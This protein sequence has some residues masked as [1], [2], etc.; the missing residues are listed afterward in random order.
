MRKQIEK[1]SGRHLASY[2]AAAGLG[3][4][5]IGSHAQAAIVFTDVD[6]DQNVTSAFEVDFDGDGFI[7]AAVIKAGLTVQV[8]SFGFDELTMGVWLTDNFTLSTLEDPSV[9]GTAYY[10]ASFAS[11]ALIDGAALQ[12]SKFG[13]SIG[14]RETAGGFVYNFIG[15]GQF[16]GIQF[17][18]GNDPGET[19]GSGIDRPAGS[20]THFGWIEVDAGPSVSAV[21]KSFAYETVPNAGILAGNTGV[22]DGDL[23]GDGF[24]GIEDLNLVLGDWN[25]SPPTD[26][27]AD[28]TGDNF[29]G[30]ED[31]NLVLGNW[32]AGTPPA[33]SALVPEPATLVLLAAGL[34]AAA[35][36]R[37]REMV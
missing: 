29:V 10:A 34:G 21:V 3:A 23:N 32:N 24:V 25:A 18:I 22:L 16:V 36:R 27:A 7:D 4:F 26:P 5:A 9:P 12:V 14:L 8:R 30:I 20:T 33:P 19:D 2:S 17:E 1:R 15:T 31:L 28:P 37:R 6:P 35:L 13:A 11:G